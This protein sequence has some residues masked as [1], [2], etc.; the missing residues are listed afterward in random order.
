MD[1]RK[2]E[3]MQTRPCKYC[4]ALQDDSVFADFDV[5]KSGCVYLVRIS[6]DGFGC[7]KPDSEVTKINQENSSFLIK[8][9]DSNQL[10]MSEVSEILMGYFHS[11]K[12]LLWEDALIEHKLI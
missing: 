2:S 10:R 12:D 8:A 6:Y 3:P 5:D 7:C 1:I 11:N 4:L 9:I